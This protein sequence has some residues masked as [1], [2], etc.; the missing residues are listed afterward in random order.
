MTVTAFDPGAHAARQQDEERRYHRRK[1][2]AADAIR[3]LLTAL[4]APCS[5]EHTRETPVR[6]A[7]AFLELLSG[8]DEDP[9]EHLCKTFPGPADGALV[10]VRGVRFTSLCAHHLLPFTGTA[11]V[12]YIPEDGAPVVGLSKLARVVEGYARR[13]Q[14][15]EILGEQIRD[16][17]IARLRT[18]AAGVVITSH[19]SCMGIRGVRQPD[20]E[21]VTSSLSGLFRDDPR[22]RAELMSLHPSP[23]GGPA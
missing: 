1:A 4:E 21:M 16:A 23:T 17:L 11:T 20:A 3:D 19:H 8:Y 6:V 2:K 13:L 22:A 7:R 12:A 9:S 10:A 14:T 18:Q 15:Q 5:D